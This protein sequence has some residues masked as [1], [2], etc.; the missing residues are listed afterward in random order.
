MTRII[1]ITIDRSTLINL[2]FCCRCRRRRFWVMI[3]L[4]WNYGKIKII[5]QIVAKFQIKFDLCLGSGHCKYYWLAF[6]WVEVDFQR[7]T[8]K[9]L[10]YINSFFA[11]CLAVIFPVTAAYPSRV[12]I[13]IVLQKKNKFT[14]LYNYS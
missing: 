4:R 3:V 7:K 1:Q 2:F 5:N 11:I 12:F 6:E 9:N 14:N 10:I 8:A 13:F